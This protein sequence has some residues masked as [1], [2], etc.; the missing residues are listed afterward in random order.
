MKTNQLLTAGACS[1]A[2][3][4][5]GWAVKL[6][7]VDPSTAP[8]WQLVLSLIA[9]ILLAVTP[10]VGVLGILRDDGKISGVFGAI[11]GSIFWVLFL[12]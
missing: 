4:L 3:A 2:M 12:R 1:L 5:F 7:H 9:T 11:L 8:E 10:L 6:I